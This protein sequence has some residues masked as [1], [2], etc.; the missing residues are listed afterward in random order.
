ML[1]HHDGF[2]LGTLAV[3]P[4]TPFEVMVGLAL[5]YFAF[6]A[7]RWFGQVGREHRDFETVRGVQEQLHELRVEVKELRR[8]INRLKPP[9]TQ[10]QPV[11]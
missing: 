1:I 10:Q 7:W 4:V 5:A 9:E 3:I 2:A 11:E 6:L 8:E